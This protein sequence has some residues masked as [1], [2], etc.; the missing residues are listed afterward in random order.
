RTFGELTQRVQRH[1][2]HGVGGRP[3]AGVRGR[4][5]LGDPGRPGIDRTVAEAALDAVE[6]TSIHCG[7]QV[8][9]VQQG[10]PDAGLLGGGEPAVAHLVGVR[11]RDTV[12]SVVQVV[13]LADRGDAGQRHLGEDRPGQGVVTVRVESAGYRVHVLTPGPEGASA[14]VGPP[15]Q[16]PVER[17]R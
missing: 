8:Y 10:D 3:D 5:Q 11:V 4:L 16:G 2:A 17:V 13:E 12:R 6:A 14:A 9:R 1:R 7:A 15:T